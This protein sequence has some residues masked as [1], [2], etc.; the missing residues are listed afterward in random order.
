MNLSALLSLVA[1]DLGCSRVLD[2]CIFLCV[3]QE[4]NFHRGRR[5]AKDR[6]CDGAFFLACSPLSLIIFGFLQS[7]SSAPGDFSRRRDVR[8]TWY[9]RRNLALVP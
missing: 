8:D 3:S 6:R 7:G 9:V 5:T 4:L 1:R 2:G